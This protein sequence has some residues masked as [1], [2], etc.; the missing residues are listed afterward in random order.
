MDH[1]QQP[2]RSRDSSGPRRQGDQDPAL[3][4]L[5]KEHLVPPGRIVG[6]DV[7]RCVA[8]IGMIATHTLAS[9][10]AEGN[11]TVVQQVAGGR[12]AALFA[13]LAG[14]SMALMS[15]RTA[16][17]TGAPWLRVAERLAARAVLVALI[18]LALGELNTSLAVILTYYGVMFLLG[19]PFL[20]LHWQGAAVLAGI[21]IV[22][23]P[24]VSHLVRPHLPEPSYESPS[25]H[26][27]VQPLHLLSELIFTGYYPAATWLPYLVAGIAV[28]RL[29]LTRREVALVLAV[30]GQVVALVGKGVSALLLDQDGV[31]ETLARTYTGP[32]SGS[33][34]EET[35]AHGLYGTTPTGSWWWLAVSAPHSGTPFDLMHTIGTSL[36]VIGI[37]LLVAPL[38]PRLC[39]VA[40]GAGAMT[41]TLYSLHVVMRIPQLWD[42][43]GYTVF[44]KH[45]AVVLVIGAAFRLAGRSGPLEKLLAV[46]VSRV[47]SAPPAQPRVDSSPR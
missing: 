31:T 46:L 18:G 19:I 1:D 29:D 5:A 13:V 2:R 21:G 26:S 11:I 7:A 32:A 33:T 12:S 17:V 24:V 25:F 6:L 43:D 8:L 34:L 37:A 27:L 28:G 3:N 35:L 39:A 38:A 4:V 30:G 36:S 20:Q 14:A 41:L 44:A 10:D 9:T 22:T 23:A 47:G 15:G 45:V 40:L 42:G 16:P